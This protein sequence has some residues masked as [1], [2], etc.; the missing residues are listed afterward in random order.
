MIVTVQVFP[1]IMAVITFVGIDISNRVVK[2]VDR[3]SFRHEICFEVTFDIVKEGA[4]VWIFF[5]FE[6]RFEMCPLHP[7]LCFLLV[8]IDD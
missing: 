1:M 7:R 6:L 8:T 4:G 5:S 2:F 3:K